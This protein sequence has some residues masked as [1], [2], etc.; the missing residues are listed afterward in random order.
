MPPQ[1]ADYFDADQLMRV[2]LQVRGRTRPIKGPKTGIFYG[3]FKQGDE[4]QIHRDD[5]AAHPV[6]FQLVDSSP[7]QGDPPPPAE[8]QPPANK[9]EATPFDL[10]SVKG[11]GESTAEVI[12]R[13]FDVHTAED[14]TALTV[15]QLTSVPN[16]NAI[17]A[18][19]IIKD[20]KEAIHVPAAG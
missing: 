16:V 11:V 18:E 17:L 19:N 8:D 14:V 10:T 7:S 9:V 13:R 5:Y 4:F 3:R 6:W 12:V 20:A 2:R 1:V 15:D